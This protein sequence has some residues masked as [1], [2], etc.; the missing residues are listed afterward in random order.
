MS[1]LHYEYKL[2]NDFSSGTVLFTKESALR[3]LEILFGQAKLV[4]PWVFAFVGVRYSVPSLL[5]LVFALELRS[6]VINS[7]V[8]G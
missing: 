8:V 7:G 5:G 4:R 6:T 3:N 2:S 1:A